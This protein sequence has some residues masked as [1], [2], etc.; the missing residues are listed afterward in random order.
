MSAVLIDAGPLIAYFD[1]SDQWH[2]S[3]SVFIDALTEQLVTTTAVITEV[4]WHLQSDFRVQNE[5][6]FRVATGAIQDEPLTK[7]DFARITELNIQ[8]AD[9][10]ADF[11]DLSLLAIAE[12]LDIDAIVST[13]GEFD[14]YR[15]KKGHRSVALR[16]IL[17]RK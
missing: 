11:A 2:R 13:D 1:Q 7:E 3:L 10:G 6:L 17:P 16:R 15:I 5:F 4:M 9:Q 12:R 8:W 14:I